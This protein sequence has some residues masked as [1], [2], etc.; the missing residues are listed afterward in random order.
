MGVYSIVKEST[1]NLDITGIVECGYDNMSEA[2]LNIVAESE[3]NFGAIMK[4]VGISEL[5]VFEK[6]GTEMV[7]ESTQVDSFF[8]KIKQFFLG[9]W[10][11]IKGL[12]KKFFAM[13]DVYI[14][15]DKDFIAKYEKE[16]VS[17]ERN[18]KNFKYSGFEYSI[19]PE[20]E[21]MGPV[22]VKLDSVISTE[23][24]SGVAN[25]AKMKTAKENA[26][27]IHEKMRGTTIGKGD[28]T[29]SEYSKALFEMFRSGESSKQELTNPN[30]TTAIA[31][32][33]DSAAAKKKAEEAMAGIEKII[34]ATIK[35]AET[36]KN[37]IVKN[38]GSTDEAA[39]PHEE[40]SALTIST[41]FAREK[42]SI[43]QVYNGALL[44]AIKDNG[45]QN[46]AIC[47]SILSYKPKKESTSWSHESS[48]LGGVKLK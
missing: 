29:A 41:D 10:E 44:T 9:I 11:K 23:V 47:A 38:I 17:I 48:F 39:K 27:T 5:A 26:E 22:A 33:K 12:F 8:A 42:L 32:L 13:L 45:R 43:L 31:E 15:S 16:L 14:K 18:L 2:S 34:Q 4:H 46:K 25:L 20:N 3:Y 7:Y 36:L 40:I 19:K 21:K 30:I 28:L 37:Q 35:D 24:G 1:T 6:S